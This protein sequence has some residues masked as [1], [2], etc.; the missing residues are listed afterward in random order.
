MAVGTPC[1]AT[2][3]ATQGLQVKPGRDVLLADDA[4]AFAEEVINLIENN[5]LNEKIAENARKF[6]EQHHTWEQIGK[7]LDQ[8]C[9]DLLK[10]RQ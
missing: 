5:Q 2:S 4:D 7:D 3:I 8:I 9:R 10:S 1:V 6:V